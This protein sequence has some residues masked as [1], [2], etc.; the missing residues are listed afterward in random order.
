M[1]RTSTTKMI[2]LVAALSILLGA[3]N[4]PEPTEEPTRAVLNTVTPGTAPTAGPTPTPLPLAN[5][6]MVDREPVQGEELQLD[7]PVVL[8]FDQ[9]MD[10][11]SVEQALQI[12]PRVDGTFDWTRD[13]VVSFKPA[14]N[15]ERAQRYSLSLS[16]TAKSTKGLTLARPEMF[17][18]STVGYL[19]VAQ[20]IP[21]NEARDVSADTRITVLFNRPVVALTAIGQQAALPSPV[22]FDPPLEGQ[23]EWLNT[24]IYLFRPSNPLAAGVNYK[25]TVAAGLQDTTGAVLENEFAWTFSVAAPT[26]KFISPEDT[27]ADV[28]LRR[29]IS[30]TFSQKMDH[31]SAEAAF[32]I[33]PPVQGTFRW[34]EEVA[35]NSAGM[36]SRGEQPQI[37]VGQLPQPAVSSGEVM[38]FVPQADYQRGTLYKV[39]IKAGA[40]ALG[41]SSATQNARSFSF[42]SI[43]NP[44]VASTQPANGE[45][46]AESSNGFA[47]RFTAPV[48]PET[49]IPNLRFEPALTLTKVYSYYDPLEKRFFLNVSLEPSTRYRVTIGGNISD[50]YGAT[51]G[52]DTLVQFTTGPLMPF[53]VLQ[54]AGQVGTY[55]ANR[56][57]RL[58]ATY[59]NVSKLD[60]E[61]AALTLDQFYQFTGADNAF[62]AIKQ[63]KPADGQSIRKWSMQT[64]AALNEAAFA[65]VALAANEGGLAPGIYMLTLTAP[66][67]AATV[68]Y[69]EPARHI[70]IVTSLHVALKQG[71]REAL[72]WVTDL[73]SGQPVAGLPV[74]FRNRTFAEIGKD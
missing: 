59:R 49:I 8:T 74:S 64:S 5:P 16:D 14:Q 50:K 4:Q 43:E 9:P 56:P 48:S 55:N 6:V 17:N 26:V 24:S 10:R 35:E 11:S 57:T 73:N 72:A 13:N 44:G 60:F 40:N 52:Q 67:A 30:I 66:E 21:A 27:T 19:E 47:I 18:V 51:I 54:T 2:G 68:Q 53:A 7:K 62:D 37:A 45:N 38:A 61:L 20:T 70:L 39:E 23:G 46:K 34:G 42:R 12:E 32:S 65:E 25:A 41:G 71:D 15:W 3:C 31:A 22:T 29:P 36:T 33:D 1:K 69:Y 28:D 58:F 63:F